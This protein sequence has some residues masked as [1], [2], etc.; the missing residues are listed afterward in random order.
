MFVI[1]VYL[2]SWNR[3]LPVIYPIIEEVIRVIGKIVFI[4]KESLSD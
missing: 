1:C 4:V 2:L 3:G